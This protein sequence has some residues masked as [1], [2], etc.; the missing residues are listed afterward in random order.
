MRL[1]EVPTQTLEEEV[2]RLRGLQESY[3]DP[4]SRQYSYTLGALVA[5]DWLL[6]GANSPSEFLERT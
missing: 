1:L 3:P 5:L 6:S 2:R 4:D